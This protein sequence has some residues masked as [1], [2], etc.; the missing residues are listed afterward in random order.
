MVEDHDKDVAEFDKA[1]TSAQ[2]SDVKGWAGKT[3]P[4]LKEHQQMAKE[5]ASKQ[6]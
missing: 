2:D 4:T 5:I 3:L 6:K 1:S